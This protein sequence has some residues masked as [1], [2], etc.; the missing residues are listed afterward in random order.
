LQVYSFKKFINPLLKNWYLLLKFHTLRRI[1]QNVNLNYTTLGVNNPNALFTLADFVAICLLLFTFKK[2]R[3][4]SMITTHC[5]RFFFVILLLSCLYPVAQVSRLDSL[6]KNIAT[7]NSASKR[8]DATLEFC[9]GWESFSPDSLYRYAMMAKQMAI[10]E[11]NNVAILISD[12]YLAAYLFQKNRLDTALKSVDSVIAKAGKLTG[13]GDTLLKFWYLRGNILQR[14]SHYDEV[15]KQDFSLLTLAEKYHDTVGMIRLN[16][17]IGNVNLRLKKNEEAL[18]WHYNAIGLMQSDAL[19]IRCS[20]VYINIAVV[21]YHLSAINDTKEIEDSIERNLESAIKYSRQGTSLTNLANGLS[22]YGNVL[23]ENK[24]LVPAEAALTEALQIR[25]KIGDIFYEIADMVALSSFYENSNNNKKAADIC[26]RALSLAKNN[27]RDFSSMNAVY[28]SLGEIY[29]NMGDYK[30]YS[31]VLK[32]KIEL[33][34]STYKVNTAEAVTEMEAKYD[35][36]KKETTILQQKYDLARKNYLIYGALILLMLLG[37][38]FIILFRQNRKKQD[39]KLQMLHEEEQKMSSIAVA[40]AEENERRRI[41][42][43]LH[44]NLGGQLSY[45]SSNMDFILDAPVHLS[46]EEKNKRLGKVNETAKSTITDLRETIWALKK[47][48]V[49]IEELAD[50]LKL[51]AQNQLAYKD[52]MRLDVKENLALN[53]ILTPAEALN[54]FRIF[55]EA[56]HNAVK[57]SGATE[58]RLVLTSAAPSIY[59]IVVADNGRGFDDTAVFAGH[60]GLENMKE[61]AK[62]LKLRLEINSNY[63]SGTTV[64]LSSAS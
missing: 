17:G 21:Y 2:S 42:A 4:T 43:E 23:S 9:D 55:Q 50:K 46:D 57:Y 58:I 1:F 10:Y 35:L 16:T 56:I 28:S 61:R 38:F 12:Y 36:Q 32:E 59:S 60:Y 31:E 18:K 20:F 3:L 64:M 15:M 40:V 45:I 48:S 8:L 41:A 26:L 29:S 44:D 34:D 53:L 39:L 63:G 13:Y 7:A 14:T 51:Y 62:E 5:R 47:E 49:E 6:K 30:N 24:K 54:V 52:E 37:I 22:M 11:K 27:G 19:K 33:Q 25:E